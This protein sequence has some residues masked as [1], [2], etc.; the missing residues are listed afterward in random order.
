M[1]PITRPYLPD[2]EDYRA[3]LEEIWQS[4]MLSNFA[5]FAQRLENL[6]SAHL[7]IPT[8]AVVSGDIGLV[9]AIAA[10]RVPVGSA[11]LVASFTFNSTVNAILWN[12]LRPVFV[13]IDPLTFNMDPVDAAK[14]GKASQA[15]LVLATHVFGNPADV[16][17]LAAVA[18]DLGARLL[19]DAAHGYGALRG[20]VPVGSFGDAEVFSLS[21]TKPVTSAEGGLI[22]SRDASFL[23]EVA[24]RRGYGFRDDYNTKM[25]GLNGKMSELHAALGLLTLGRVDDALNV[26]EGHVLRYRGLLAETPG[27]AFQSIRPEDRPTYKDFAVLFSTPQ[28]RALAEEDLRRVDVQTKRYF[29]P[30]HQMDAYRVFAERAL[31]MTEDL[32]SRVLCVPLFEDIREVEIELVAETIRRTE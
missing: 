3:L 25:L 13:D 1:I 27:I 17:G 12:Q 6:A 19:F 14:M 2:L 28:R 31:P 22:S 23:D 9:L 5:A 4:R 32:Y 16:D 7:G 20:G 21:A 24:Y 10:L 11:C 29:R 26:R 15:K 30:C 18:N 8:V